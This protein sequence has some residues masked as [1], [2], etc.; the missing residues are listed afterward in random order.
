[1]N[2]F[3]LLIVVLFGLAS[4]LSPT[5]AAAVATGNFWTVENQELCVEADA[6]GESA[7]AYKPCSKK[8]NGKAVSCQQLA[9]VMPLA[10]ECIFEQQSAQFSFPARNG[11]LSLTNDGRFRPPQSA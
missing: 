8:I 3:W 7:L 9:G 4:T 2:R 6:A 5:M 1:M 10:A 11:S